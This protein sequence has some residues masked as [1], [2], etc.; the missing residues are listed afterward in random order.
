MAQEGPEPEHRATE[1]AYP[2][3][4]PQAD[5][6]GGFAPDIAVEPEGPA[7]D[8]EDVRR[9]WEASDPIDGEAPTG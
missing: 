2:R 3:D 9:R 5:Q 8:E 7:D 6:N 1:P 4:E